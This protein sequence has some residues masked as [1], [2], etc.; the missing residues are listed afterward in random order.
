MSHDDVDYSKLFVK[1]LLRFELSMLKNL[2][3]ISLFL[4]TFILR[5]FLCLLVNANKALSFHCVN[6]DVSLG[7][8]QLLQNAT[9]KFAN[10]YNL[11][12]T[13]R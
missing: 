1:Q 6:T 9:Y 11:N 12:D 7:F 8:F 13:K 4:D 3:V 5:G 2:N 10:L